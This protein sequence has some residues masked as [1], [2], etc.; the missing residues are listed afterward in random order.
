MPDE[1]DTSKATWR[2]AQDPHEELTALARDLEGDEVRILVR[3]ARRLW[4]GRQRYGK[5]KLLEDGRNL[6]KEAVEELLDWLVY[7][8]SD[9]EREE[10]R[11]A[12]KPDSGE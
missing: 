7:T 3:V 1:H 8:E 10:Q 11:K 2:Q 12:A 6:Q 4:V 9:L 5:L